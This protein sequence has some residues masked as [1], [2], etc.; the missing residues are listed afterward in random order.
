M[1][2]VY[3]GVVYTSM[4]AVTYTVNLSY[5]TLLTLFAPDSKDRNMA[6]MVRSL[7]AMLGSL[8][9]GIISIPL[10]TSFGVY[11]SQRAWDKIAIIYSV[12]YF[13]MS[14]HYF[15]WCKKRKNLQ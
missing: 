13:D 11:K 1:K 15:Y 10:L 8:V 14:Y 3:A 2:I 4:T 6:A 5:I 7:F 9:V 12:I